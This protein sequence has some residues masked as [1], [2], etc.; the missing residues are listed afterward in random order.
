MTDTFYPYIDGVVSFLKSIAKELGN[1]NHEVLI[2]APKY[3][4]NDE[5]DLGKNVKVI[6]IESVKLMNYEDF[7][8]SKLKFSK[9]EKIIKNFNPDLIHIQTPAPMGIMGEMIARKNK[10][11]CIGTYHTYL[12]DFVQCISPK[13]FINW[14]KIKTNHKN[15]KNK[16]DFLYT[17]INPIIKIFEKERLKKKD[18]SKDDKKKLIDLIVWT[19]TNS[20]YNK[21]DLVTTPTKILAQDLKKHKLKRPIYPISNGLDLT[22]FSPKN[23]YDFKGKFLHVGRISFEKEIDILIKGFVF[24]QKEYRNISLDI[25]GDGP[26]LEELKLM[27]KNN[28]YEN[29]VFQGRVPRE[30]L[31]S[32]YRNHDVFLTSSPIETQG[33]VAIEAA[34]CG[35]PLIGVNRLG[36]KE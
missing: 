8:F 1:H 14:E 13:N 2:L 22:L 19:Y 11:P 36:L 5:I 23:K 31:P 30:D 34:S 3:T 21:C 7:K 33:L 4:N 16:S 10:I 18:Y 24:A 15:M 29:I 27:V 26:A 32:I 9:V 28:N 12:P 25:Y 35:L 6:R 20:I 17:L